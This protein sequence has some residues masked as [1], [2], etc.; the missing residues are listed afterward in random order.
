MF[1]HIIHALPIVLC[2]ASTPALAQ[3]AK[4][5][6]RDSLSFDGKCKIQVVDAS[7]PCNGGAALFHLVNDRTV[8]FFGSPAGMFAV[9][10]GLEADADGGRRLP[11]DTMRLKIGDHDEMVDSNMEGEC[12]I[13]IA[14]ET[15]KHQSIRCDVRDKVKKAKF[16]FYLTDISASES[17]P[18][19]ATK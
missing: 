8:I 19:P 3:E 2:A 6:I 10:G 5:N 1:R 18:G 11:I 14:R 15:G 7:V 9:S 16:S 17:K 4:N 13:A 12:R